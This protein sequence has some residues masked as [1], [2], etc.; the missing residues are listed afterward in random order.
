MA[1]NQIAVRIGDRQLR[2]SNLDKVLY[3]GRR[4]FTNGAQV[5]DYYSPRVAP[6][7]LPHLTGRR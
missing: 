6:M 7:M 1:D 2:L 3:P 4:R 5:L